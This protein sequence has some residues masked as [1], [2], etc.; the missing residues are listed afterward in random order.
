M[1]EVKQPSF[2]DVATSFNKNVIS[3]DVLRITDS[4]AVKRSIKNLV[5]TRKY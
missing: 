2:S 5:F 4:E 3:K 1:S